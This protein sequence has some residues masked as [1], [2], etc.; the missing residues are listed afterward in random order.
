MAASAENVNINTDTP[1]YQDNDA[2]SEDSKSPVSVQNGQWQTYMSD[3]TPLAQKR[4]WKKRDPVSIERSNLVNI[5]KL[6]VKELIESSLKF[7]RQLDSDSVPLQ[8]FFIVLEHVLRHGLKPKRGILG[9]KKELW[10]LFQM[11]EKWSYEAQDITASVRDLPTVKTHIGRAR[12]WLRLALMQKKLADYFRLLIE[13]RDDLLTEFYESGALMLAD[14]AIVIMGLLVGLNVIDCNL[15]VKE[16]DL[17]SQ[18]GVIDFSLYLRN[19]GGDTSPD[20][21]PEQSDMT[22]VLD[23]KNYIEE[24]NRHLNATV[25]NLQAKMETLTTTNALM[26]EDL[27]IAKN[28]ILHL[29]EDNDRLRKD[30][31]LPTQQQQEQLDKEAKKASRISVIGC[32]EEMQDLKRQLEEES[33]HRKQVEKELELQIQMKAES[34]MAAKLLEKDIH[35][36]QDT[37]ISL[38]QQLDDI[39]VINLEMYRKLQE[40]ESSLKQKTELIARLEDK[41]AEM[42]ETI[43]NLESKYE[44][45]VI[46]KEAAKET[47]QRLSD[48]ISD[49]ELYS[50]TIET[51]LKIEREWRQSLQEALVKDREINAECQQKI[52]ELRKQQEE[53]NILKGAHMQLISTVENQERTLEELGAHLSESKLKMA[54][55]RDVSKSLRDAQWAPDKEATNC[56]LCEKEFSISRRRHHCRHCGNIFCHSCSDNTMPLPSSA[57]PVRVCDTCH[58]QLLQRYSNSEN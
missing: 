40:C 41:A 36:K 26:K 29:Q 37:I 16:E 56:R 28:S 5:C 30:K 17:D 1:L 7:G 23:Q 4:T 50:S 35:E 52:A 42:A 55:L 20:D 39:K 18:M 10:D 47:A 45:C 53:Y 58:T 44:E 25:T 15:C 57:R 51:D 49:G 2:E 38:R 31:G 11:V 6:V 12:A 22:T 33:A 27:A 13:R 46:Q 9:P 43:R 8:H 14:E 19:A 32:E 48:K 34:E 3:R 21:S 54:D 24:L